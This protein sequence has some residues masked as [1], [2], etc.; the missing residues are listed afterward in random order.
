MGDEQ[1]QTDATEDALRQ[2]PRGNGGPMTDKPRKP[3]HVWVSIILSC[4]ALVI[5]GLSVCNVVR[6]RDMIHQMERDMVVQDS[7]RWNREDR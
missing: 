3:P 1:D 2:V 5:S 7:L 4:A 6:Q